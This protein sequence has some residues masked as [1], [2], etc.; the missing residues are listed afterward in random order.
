MLFN[1]TDFPVAALGSCLKNGDLNQFKDCNHTFWLDQKICV[2]AKYKFYLAFE[3]TV[4]DDYV[5]EKF[6]ASFLSSSIPVY[7]GAPNIHKFSPGEHS[8]INVHDFKTP[9]DLAEYL[10]YLNK[11]KTAY[12]EYFEWRKKPLSQNYLEKWRQ[13]TPSMF[14]RLCDRLARVDW[15]ARNM[16]TSKEMV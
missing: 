4:I 3:N 13:G 15:E 2:M 8:F 9:K 6:F 16:T 12:D 1:N 7:R 10:F 11:N 5:T 14:C